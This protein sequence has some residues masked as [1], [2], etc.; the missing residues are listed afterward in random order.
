MP[1][2]FTLLCQGKKALRGAKV[3]LG[4]Q[5]AHFAVKG[6]HTGDISPLMLKDL[7]CA[8]VILGHSERRADHFET[9]ELVAKR[10]PPL[11]KPV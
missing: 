7:G 9:N 8:Y 1:A 6:A 5:D 10:Q 4:A 2:F 11:T 3:A